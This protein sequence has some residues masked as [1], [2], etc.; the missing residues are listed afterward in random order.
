MVKEKSK[1]KLMKRECG[2]CQ[3]CCKLLPVSEIHKPANTK[4]VHQR[5]HKGCLVY[6]TNKMPLSCHVWN[7]RWLIN[8]DTNDLARPD[9]SHY[10]IDIM[11]DAVLA[12]DGDR[13][14]QIQTV[15]IWVDPKYPNAYKDLRLREYLLRR[16]KEG[17]VGQ[18]RFDSERSII[19]IPPNMNIENEWV[20]KPGEAKETGDVQKIV[21]SLEAQGRKIERW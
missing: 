18:I 19:L 17:I 7:C 4:C 9:R 5:V 10:V 14:V 8:N 21:R 3:L 15:Q 16:G 13:V 2:D 20:E 6:Y 12:L 11:P 1:G